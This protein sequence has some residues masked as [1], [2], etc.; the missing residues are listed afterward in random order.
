VATNSTRVTIFA[1]GGTI[2]SMPETQG[3]GVVPTL[4][5]A[6]L[7]DSVPAVRGIADL[8]LIQFRHEPSGDLTIEHVVDL[9]RAI[10]DRAEAT[11]GFVV[12]QGTD[13]LEET[14]YLLDLLVKTEQPVVLTGAMRSAAAPGA[15][16]PANLVA[17][18]KVA[19]A[20]AAKGIGPVI[21]FSDEIHLARLAKKTHVASVCAF[22]S[23][24]AGPIGWVSEDRV[25]IVLVPRQRFRLE[26]TDHSVRELP[27]I[28][29]AKLGLGAS[30]I[31]AGHVD[32]VCG[33][34]VEG[35]GSG[36]VPLRIVDSLVAINQRMPVVFAS[37][38]GAGECFE[39]TYGFPGSES[40]LLARGLISAGSLDGQK[41]RLL[42]ALLISGGHDRE[43]IAERFREATE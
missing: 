29:I 30:P 20:T 5:A 41:A 25:R 6:E 38:T 7:V 42:L 15:D 16:G 3:R 39:S 10:D 9:A 34:V 28:P 8:T 4:S 40:D 23:P 22:K 21:V 2:A 13:T 35:F 11:D 17:A 12:V 37:R 27:T 14:G 26:P 33:L 32:G 43:S 1:L 36:H 24:N 18:V 19:A 31:A